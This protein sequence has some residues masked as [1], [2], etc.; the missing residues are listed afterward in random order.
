MTNGCPRRVLVGLLPRMPPSLLDAAAASAARSRSSLIPFIL[1]TVTG[2]RR[3][4]PAPSVKARE[5][6]GRRK[7]VR[8][9]SL[10]STLILGLPRPSD[11]AAGPSC[12]KRED[13]QRRP[14]AKAGRLRSSVVICRSGS[15]WAALAAWCTRAAP[16]RRRRVG[17]AGA[18]VR[19]RAWRIGSR[20]RFLQARPR[21]SWGN[22]PPRSRCPAEAA[23][24]RGGRPPR[25]SLLRS[26]PHGRDQVAG[27]PWRACAG[28]CVRAAFGF[29]ADDAPCARPGNL[30]GRRAAR[31]AA[32]CRGHASSS[33]RREGASAR[34]GRGRLG[35][36]K[37][38][39]QRRPPTRRG[40]RAPRGWGE[41]EDQQRT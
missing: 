13:R 2:P 10:Y 11:R 37:T 4:L 8:P 1:A 35:R 7:G 18:D 27:L 40:A 30:V 29:V 16:Q 33:P 23:R 26:E 38:A 34:A 21:G 12:T 22:T 39:P 24:G 17:C 20:P 6:P 14:G 36:R 9:G 3:T 19:A 15:R 28:G 25:P 31:G 32:T 5:A 41:A